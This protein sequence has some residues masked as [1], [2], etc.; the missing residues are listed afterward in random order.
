M[1]IPTVQETFDAIVVEVCA[2][3]GIA[4]AVLS[5]AAHR[6][7]RTSAARRVVIQRM[8]AVGF[9]EKAIARLLNMT[10]ASVAYHI[11]PGIRANSLRRRKSYHGAARE[12][13]SRGVA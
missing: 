1:T 9:A 3:H 6:S 10:E 13:N 2:E 11:Y 7:R 8:H 5:S 12:F 4:P